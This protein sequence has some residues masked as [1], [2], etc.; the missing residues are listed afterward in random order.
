MYDD[1]GW[2]YAFLLAPVQIPL[3]ERL[4]LVGVA[5]EMYVG[6]QKQKKI[7]RPDYEAVIKT[8]GKSG[9]LGCFSGQQFTGV[10]V[11]SKGRYDLAFLVAKQLDHTM[12]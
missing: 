10:V 7:V 4:H 1:D 6:K 8:E 3:E 12:N 2:D 11:T 5:I 9:L